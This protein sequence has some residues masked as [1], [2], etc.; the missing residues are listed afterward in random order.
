MKRLLIFITILLCLSLTAF[1]G[2]GQIT[3]SADE[4]L[5]GAE[6]EE[7]MDTYDE[8]IE[9]GAVEDDLAEE[10]M[11]EEEAPYEEDL[12][13]EEENYMDEPEVGKI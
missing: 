12:G 8:V 9:E 4:Y 13:P 3:A 6:Y 7:G 11:M 2:T 5:E 1:I 10:E